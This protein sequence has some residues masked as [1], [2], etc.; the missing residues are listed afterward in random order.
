MPS[1]GY[2]LS[3]CCP[4]AFGSSWSTA[5]GSLRCCWPDHT[6]TA[7]CVCHCGKG[8]P[9]GHQVT[10]PKARLLGEGTSTHKRAPT[11]APLFNL[12]TEYPAKVSFIPWNAFSFSLGIF[13]S[14]VWKCILPCL[15]KMYWIIW[16]TDTILKV[17]HTFVYLTLTTIVQSTFYNFPNDKIEAQ[18]NEMT[19]LRLH[20]K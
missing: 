10:S 2:G 3:T 4:A 18:R 15:L 6:Q 14:V 7:P 13:N 12:G 16:C 11:L 5:S 19:W 20:S 17:S 9:A 8:S 1:V